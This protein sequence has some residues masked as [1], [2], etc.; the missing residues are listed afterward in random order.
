M[1]K[2]GWLKFSFTIFYLSEAICFSTICRLQASF[3]IIIDNI[4][5]SISS[6]I[7][8]IDRYIH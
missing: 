1:D 7:D 6:L 4:K 2:N 5:N 3:R 8:L